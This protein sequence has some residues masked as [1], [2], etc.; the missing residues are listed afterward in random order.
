VTSV[1]AYGYDAHGRVTSDTREVAGVQYLLAYRYDSAGRLDQLTYPSGRTVNQAFDGL[2]RVS[3]VTTTKPGEQAQNVVTGVTYL[4]FGG[5]RGYTLGNGQV[6]TRGIDLDGRIASY[7]LG[8]QSFAIGYDAAS[9]I[10]FISEVTNPPNTNTYG[11]D[12]L[13]RLTSAVLPGTPYAYSYD[14][15]GNR[16]SRTAGASTHTYAY[17][18]TSNRIASIT[19]TSGPVR[20]FVFDPNGSTTADGVNTYVYDARGRMV[21]ATSAIGATNYQV[22]ALGQRIRKTISQADR[23]FHYD[24]QGKLIVETDAGGAL[25]RELIYLGDIPV[26]VVQ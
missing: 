16:T 5:V 20:S 14:A 13:D 18:F 3:A 21:Q 2:G 26:G 23:V 22:N 17:S 25:K 15:V 6:Y 9:R 10:E 1:I 4:P 19:P 12:E 8:T 24:T 7:T 11:Y